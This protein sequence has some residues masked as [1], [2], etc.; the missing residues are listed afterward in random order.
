MVIRRSMVSRRGRRLIAA[1]LCA[2]S[3]VAALLAVGSASPVA[4]SGKFVIGDNVS[5]DDGSP[6]ANVGVDLFQA[7]NPS[8]RGAFLTSTRTGT[9]G[10]YNVPVDP[11]CY[12]AVFLALPGTSFGSSSSGQVYSQRYVCIEDSSNYGIDEVLFRSDVKPPP[13]KPS[14]D[15]EKFVNGQDA[16]T[17]PGPTINADSTA[18]FTYVVTNN[19]DVPLERVMVTDNV[20]GAISC[21]QTTLAIGASMNCTPTTMTVVVGQ[22]TMESCAKGFNNGQQVNDCDPVYWTVPPPPQPPSTKITECIHRHKAGFVVLA[23]G[24]KPGSGFVP[25]PSVKST[26]GEELISYATYS[27]TRGWGLEGSRFL[28]VKSAG[29]TALAITDQHGITYPVPCLIKGTPIG[30]DLDGSGAVDRIEGSFS[31]DLDGDGITE[32]LNEWFAPTEGILIN[33]TVE[34]TGSGQLSGASLFGDMG[35]RYADGYHKLAAL[36]Q[37]SDS[38]VSGTELT[39]LA[40]WSDANSNA[41]LDR[42]ELSSLS[43]HG[44]VALST[45]HTNMVSVAFRANGTTMITEDIWFEIIPAATTNSSGTASVVLL[46]LLGIGVV[47]YALV[48]SRRRRNNLDAEIAELLTAPTNP[49]QTHIH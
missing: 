34:G 25:P 22:H 27:S 47:G 24:A 45:S 15:I 36:D 31:F 3:F 10:S 33:T 16:D 39:G 44:L 2:T 14:I 32:T 30:L 35:G 4:A 46:G 28:T 29:I 40:L 7:L 37:N 13:S 6:A 20:A 11:G 18:T 38:Q 26:S 19:G 23:A 5:I 49:E 9:N 17:P 21:P 1:I 12:I 43:D 48:A 42:G 41:R 8:Q